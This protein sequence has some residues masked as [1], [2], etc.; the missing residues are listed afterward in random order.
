MS[1]AKDRAY[2]LGLTSPILG[3]R[4]NGESPSKVPG[5]NGMGG[6]ALEGKEGD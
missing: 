5:L 1:S 4:L 2:G 3:V 6:A